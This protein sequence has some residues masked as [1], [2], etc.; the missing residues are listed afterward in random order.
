MA[1]S[2]QFDAAFKK[3]FVPVLQEAGFSGKLPNFRSPD[4]GGTRLLFV[5]KVT[6][7]E[8]GKGGGGFRLGLGYLPDWAVEIGAISKQAAAEMTAPLMPVFREFLPQRFHSY[9]E[10]EVEGLEALVLRS[11]RRFRGEGIRWYQRCPKGITQRKEPSY[12]ALV[13]LAKTQEWA[14]AFVLR[15]SLSPS[16]KSFLNRQIAAGG[17]LAVQAAWALAKTGDKK[18]RALLEEAAGASGAG[19]TRAAKKLA[20]ELSRIAAHAISGL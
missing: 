11:A 3:V 8:A 18:A 1:D 20:A 15:Q 2:R 5:Q 6:T 16:C 4:H 7:I 17:E 13:E 19:K 12:D 10:L 14:L 9:G